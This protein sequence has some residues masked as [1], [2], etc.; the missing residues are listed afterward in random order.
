MTN[1]MFMMYMLLW[2]IKI[3]KNKQ[4]YSP[5]IQ[6]NKIKNSPS[7]ENFNRKKDSGMRI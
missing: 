2:F 6:R 7:M 3:L 5:P 1:T 4:F